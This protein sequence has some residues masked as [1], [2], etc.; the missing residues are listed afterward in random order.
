MPGYGVSDPIDP[1]TYR[2]I[3]DA[4]VRL[5]DDVG[6]E[7]ATLVGESFGGMHAL[8][9]AIHYPDRVA[10]LVL[11]N[12]SPA[13]GMDGT[14]AE[15]WQAA[16]LGPLDAGR[17]PSDFAEAVLSSIAGPGLTSEAMAMRVSAFGRI[18]ADAL[19]ASVECLP[20]NDV[21]GDLASIQAPSLVIAGDLDEE[22]PVSYAKTLA[23]GL[24][25]A[26]LVVLAGVG[27]L[28]ATEDP[29]RFNELVRGF[30]AQHPLL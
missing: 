17:Q 19:R 28:A 15:E 1:L 16:R 23:D 22:T 30:I 9:T 18:S 26:Q 11:T 21:R 5:L 4:V 2:R 8:H 7:R 29:K 10:R 12:T 24:P 27:H 3:A 14:G 13:F 25:N 6:V 20:S